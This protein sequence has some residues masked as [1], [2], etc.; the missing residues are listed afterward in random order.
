MFGR[1]KIVKQLNYQSRHILDK[2]FLWTS[3]INV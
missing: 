1:L 3:G 2:Q